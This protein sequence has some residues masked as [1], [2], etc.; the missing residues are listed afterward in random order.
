LCIGPENRPIGIVEGE[1][2][3]VEIFKGIPPSDGKARDF[4]FG[5]GNCSLGLLAGLDYLF[6]IEDARENFVLLPSGSRAFVNINGTE[7]KRLFETLR[8]LRSESEQ[9]RVPRFTP[10]HSVP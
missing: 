5:P 7:P 1:F 8:R 3:V 10:S 4:I 6:F 2:R 9:R